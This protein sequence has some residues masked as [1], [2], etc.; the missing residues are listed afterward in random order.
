MRVNSTELQNNFG[1]YLVIAATEDI[2]I[3]RNGTVIAKLS[4][5][6]STEAGT[7][8][9]AAE[10][11]LYGGRK[12]PREEFLELIENT[13]ERYEYIDGEIYYL[14]SPKTAHQAALTELFGMFFN[15]F[16]GKECSVFVAPY[17]IT[18]KRTEDDFN[19]VQPDIMVIC[20]LKEKLDERDYYMGVPALL[21]EIMSESTK[22]K[23]L[24]KKLDLYM[25]SGVR[26]YW[27]INPQNREVTVYRFENKDIADSFTYRK[28]EAAKSFLFE[29]LSVELSR[30]FK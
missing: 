20:N 12:A 18:L 8:S 22:R 28:P 1:K 24:T 2:I 11:Y 25:D 19:L 6:K 26:E 5:I 4:G 29:G 27:I 10:Q 16:Q 14:A 21:V 15:W 13:E 9:E 17:D 7:V 23:D 3:T 30:V